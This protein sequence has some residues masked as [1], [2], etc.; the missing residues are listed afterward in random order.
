VALF[1]GLPIWT[2]IFRWMANLFGGLAV[3]RWLHPWAGV[4][5]VAGAAA[6]FAKW[7]KEMHME[8]QDWEWIGP[9]GLDYF[10]RRGDD[11]NVGKYNGGQ[12]LFFYLV[13]LLAVT[14]LASGLLLWFP[15]LFPRVLR[16]FAWVI[17][18]GAFIFFAAAIVVHIYLGT[19]ALPGTFRS[20]TR[21]TVSTGYARTHHGRWYREITGGK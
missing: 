14:L 10:R 5:F 18:D 17:H 13:A 1:T 4:A 11:R 16:E 19:A 6:M 12:K 3:C 8:R 15:L 20:M 7:L 9:K 21:G 2:Q